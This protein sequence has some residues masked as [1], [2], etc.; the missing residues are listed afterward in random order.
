MTLSFFWLC[1]FLVKSKQLVPELVEVVEI[2]VVILHDVSL[3]KEGLILNSVLRLYYAKRSQ[4]K[5]SSSALILLFREIF[6]RESKTTTIKTYTG[7][8]S[9]VVLE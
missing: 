5:A 9:T 8:S 7:H 6:P 1:M 3:E 4:H 2:F